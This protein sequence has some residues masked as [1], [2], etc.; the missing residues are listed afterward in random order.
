MIHC[1]NCGNGI[2]EE[3]LLPRY[4]PK[5]LGLDGVVLL[6]AVKEARCSKCGEVESITIPNLQG[7]IASV[8]VCRVKNPLKLKG[9][10]IRFL[11]K[12]M[13]MTGSDLAEKLDYSRKEKVSLWENDQEPMSP[14]S[15]RLLRILVGDKL[16]EFSPISI[17]SNEILSMRIQ[18]WHSLAKPLVMEFVLV[19]MPRRRSRVERRGWK[20]RE[21]KKA[22]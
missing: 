14:R 13:E 6:N 19:P 4:E 9:V 7:L 2:G 15:E 5:D 1:S 16:G 10:E 22:A 11:R 20:K 12:A 17:T 21:E 8:A 3:T 18:A